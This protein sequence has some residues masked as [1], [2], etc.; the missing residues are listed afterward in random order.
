[1]SPDLALLRALLSLVA[2]LS[3]MLLLAWGWRRF[4]HRLGLPGTLIAPR[5]AKRLQA[6]ETLRLNPHTTLHIVKHDDTEHLIA[7]TAAQTTI[8]HTRPAKK[9]GRV[10]A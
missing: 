6:L 3:F 9:S 8:I 10:K 2:T 7:T 4:G 1:M 5:P